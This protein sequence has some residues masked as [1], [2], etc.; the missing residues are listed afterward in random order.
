MITPY[1]LARNQYTDTIQQSIT[2][3]ALFLIP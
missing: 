1:G 2:L 3:D